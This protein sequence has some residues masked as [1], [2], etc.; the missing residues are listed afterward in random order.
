MRKYKGATDT[1]KLLL[2]YWFA[3]D[4][5]TPGGGSFR[6]YPA[7]RDAVETLVYAL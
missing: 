7:Q 2:N 1:T 5:R 4:H 3:T 6:Y